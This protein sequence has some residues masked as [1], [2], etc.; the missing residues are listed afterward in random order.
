MGILSSI[1]NIYQG[2]KQN[3][4]A[5]QIDPVYTPYTA[6][7]YAASTLGTAEQAYNGRMAGAASL[8]QNIYGNAANTE[9]QVAKTATDGSQA[10]AVE[11]ATQA[12]AG[13]QFRTL[14]TTEEQNKYQLL[15]N[16]N[17]ANS[18]ETT[19]GDKVYQAQLQKYMMDTQQ[20]AALRGAGAKNISSGI[21][22]AEGATGG[23]GILGSVLGMII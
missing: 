11:A 2:A 10:L 19:E 9:G 4:E 5:N 17:L 20:Q 6:S 15:N 3:S 23:S 1:F 16:L 22:G 8:E 18:Q 21:S 7:P 12:Q 14:Q 13:G